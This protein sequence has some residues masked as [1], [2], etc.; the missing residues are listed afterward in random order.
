MTAVLIPTRAGSAR[1]RVAPARAPRR[2]TLVVVS[3][4]PSR[5]SRR[6]RRLALFAGGLV[7]A[8]F[9][10]VAFHALLAQSQV[11]ID[12]LEQRTATAERRYEDARYQHAVLASPA[13]IVARAAEL[14]LVS[15]GQP[16]T[17][18]P[19]EGAL[20]PQ[21]DGVGSTLHGWTEV[22]PTLVAAP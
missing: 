16:P 19:V 3:P 22:K 15:P 12:R 9:T 6:R 20:P 17:A 2:P 13:R 8:L 4:R 14:G 11:A 18:V 5:V 21:P 1:T 10:V 7:G